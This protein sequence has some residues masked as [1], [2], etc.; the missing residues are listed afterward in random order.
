MQTNVSNLVKIDIL[1]NHIILVYYILRI[2][3][4]LGWL[5]YVL[6]VVFVKII[7]LYCKKD[8]TLSYYL[9]FFRKVRRKRFTIMYYIICM[10]VL[11]H[12]SIIMANR[13]ANN[14][15]LWSILPLQHT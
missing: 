7:V 5:R 1:F 6:Q 3:M 2:L 14:K 11:Y 12:V 4:S 10:Y 15:Q 8:D 13:L 9:F